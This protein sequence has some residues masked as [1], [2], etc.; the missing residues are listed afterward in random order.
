MPNS[1]WVS[2]EKPKAL[3]R[4]WRGRWSQSQLPSS[5]KK[6]K[7]IQFAKGRKSASWLWPRSVLARLVNSAVVSSLCASQRVW[8]SG[9]S[10]SETLNSKWEAPFRYSRAGNPQVAQSG[11][12]CWELARSGLRLVPDAAAAAAAAAAVAAEQQKLH[13]GRVRGR[14]AWDDV[15]LPPESVNGSRFSILVRT[16]LSRSW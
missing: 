4:G 6:K 8:L 3:G 1:V 13:T 14:R 9:C 2:E 15:L 10:D 5:L 7:K 11:G 16:W 12:C